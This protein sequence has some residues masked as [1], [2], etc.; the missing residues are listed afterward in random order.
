M[1]GG[2]EERL[3]AIDQNLQKRI[4]EFESSEKRLA[5]IETKVVHD[6][7]ELSEKFKAF[8]VEVNE[9]LSKL[10]NQVDQSV[11]DMKKEMADLSKL[12]HTSNAP[13]SANQS[14]PT[15]L[16]SMDT[17]RSKLDS[18]VDTLIPNKEVPMRRRRSETRQIK[19]RPRSQLVESNSF[20]TMDPIDRERSNS[21]SSLA[22]SGHGTLSHQQSKESLPVI[23]E[24]GS[25]EQQDI[26]LSL[27]NTSS[28]FSPVGTTGSP[29]LRHQ[30]KTSSETHHNIVEIVWAMGDLADQ[31]KNLAGSFV[32]DTSTSDT[33]KTKI[34]YNDQGLVFHQTDSDTNN[35]IDN[36]SIDNNGTS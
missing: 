22:S 34:D 16:E 1:K 21:T 31:L 11:E 5:N 7:D 25:P 10:Q 24:I 27:S 26:S 13:P 30:S 9:K 20:E 18:L 29:Q 14:K 15:F 23:G 33:C 12:Y 4:K 28:F 2:L 35:G 6:I 32:D 36:N 17:L 19:S 3:Q 8:Q